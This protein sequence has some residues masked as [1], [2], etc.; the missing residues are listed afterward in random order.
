MLAVLSRVNHPDP[1]EEQSHRKHETQA[2]ADPPDTLGAGVVV[3]REDDQRHDARADETQV[4]REIRGE[5]HEQAAST[6]DK[7]AFIR[8]LRGAR[9]TVRPRH[10]SQQSCHK[11]QERQSSP[12]G[13]LATRAEASDAA[14]HDHHPEHAQLRVAVGGRGQDDTEDEEQR[15]EDDAGAPTDAIDEE[16]EEQHAEDLANQVGVREPGLD[17]LG[18]ALLVQV[19][20]QR[21][22]VPDDLSIVAVAGDFECSV[23]IDVGHGTLIARAHLKSANPETSTVIVDEVFVTRFSSTSSTP[24]NPSGTDSSPERFVLSTTT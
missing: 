3:R 4:D 19:A 6:T 21:F 1:E 18:H 10:Q 9:P 23:L 12:C 8:S 7:V 17:D 14:G 16:A 20:E 13:I 22:H 11:A 2:E 15:R 24:E 5:S